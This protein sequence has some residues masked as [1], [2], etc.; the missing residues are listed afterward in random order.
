MWPLGRMWPS[1]TYEKILEFLKFL[2]NYEIYVFV[3][4]IL[5]SFILNEIF[6]YCYVC[7]CVCV[8]I[9][10]YVCV[11]VCMCVNLCVCVN[12]YMY[13]CDVND[14]NWNLFDLIDRGAMLGG[15]I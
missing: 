15:S 11:F 1:Y 6:C 9:C 13:E 5:N 3:I 2:K 12:D 7:V 10:V 4:I 14:T 8:C